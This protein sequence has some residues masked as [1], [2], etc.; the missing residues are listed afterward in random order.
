MP[1]DSNPGR[2][3]YDSK[4]KAPGLPNPSLYTGQRPMTLRERLEQNAAL[5]S[6]RAGRGLR[7]R[8]QYRRRAQACEY[9]RHGGP[10]AGQD[11]AQVG[12]ARRAGGFCIRQQRK[13][14][15]RRS[16]KTRRAI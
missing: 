7:F 8:G 2:D 11:D 13:G 1:K 9:C 3:S 12:S 14:S 15:K 6:A 10:R 16:I 4:N 5:Q